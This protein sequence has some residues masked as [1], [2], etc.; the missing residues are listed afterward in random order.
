MAAGLPLAALAQAWPVKP[1]TL[2]VGV[3][4]GGALD[5]YARA[6]ADQ[7]A[8]QTGGTFVVDNKPGANGNLSAEAVLKAPADGHTLWIGTESM[9]TINPA[10][11]AQL[12]WKPTDFK[13]VIKGVEAPLVLVTHASVPARAR[14]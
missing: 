3:P 8:R 12:R 4:S 13:P 10:A 6:L 7:L 5:P 1:V 11:S 14:W 2:V 9:M